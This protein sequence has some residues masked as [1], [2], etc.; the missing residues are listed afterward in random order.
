MGPDFFIPLAP[1][2]IHRRSGCFPAFFAGSNSFVGLKPPRKGDVLSGQGDA[3][4]NFHHF[5]LPSTLVVIS[6]KAAKLY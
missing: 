5:L 4:Q 6:R 3:R 1:S 2:D